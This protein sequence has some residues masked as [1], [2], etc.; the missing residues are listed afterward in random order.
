MGDLCMVT[1]SADIWWVIKLSVR[2]F[3]YEFG[4]GHRRIRLFARQP[5][6]SKGEFT[7]KGKA[8]ALPK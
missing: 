4:L 5:T 1:D 7:P 2:I 8:A 6:C 3:Q